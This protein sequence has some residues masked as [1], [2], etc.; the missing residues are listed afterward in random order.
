M[1]RMLSM[2]AVQA[3]PIQGDPTA[4]REAFLEEATRLRKMFP[5]VQLLLY[6]ELHLSGLTAFGMPHTG[7]PLPASTEA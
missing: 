3:R 2:L 1:T 7:T 5:G 4:T 6:P